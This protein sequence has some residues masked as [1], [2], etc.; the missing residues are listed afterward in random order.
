MCLRG[1]VNVHLF[2]SC[3]HLYIALS[4]SLES[5]YIH[6]LTMTVGAHTVYA[7][8]HGPKQRAV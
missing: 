8:E 4:Y 3:F 1:D 2:G 6:T 5:Q 7:A